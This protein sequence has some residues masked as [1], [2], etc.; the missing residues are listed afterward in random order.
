MN[1][2]LKISSI[3]DFSLF[4]SLSA[5]ACNITFPLSINITSSKIRSISDIERI[6]YEVIFIDKGKIILQSEAYKLRKK[7]KGSID[8]IFRRMF[9]C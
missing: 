2:L 3:D 7:E 4:L 5:S 1:I 8:E 9:K 6:L